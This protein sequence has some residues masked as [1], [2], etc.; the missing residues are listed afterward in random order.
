MLAQPQIT[1]SRNWTEVVPSERAPWY[2]GDADIKEA[3][4]EA[5]DYS[6][7][8]CC[9]SKVRQNQNSP[10]PPADTTIE[11]KSNRN[12]SICERLQIL[13]LSAT[14][15]QTTGTIFKRTK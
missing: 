7:K 3:S 11:K 8:H 6:Y 14:D 1:P 12:T 9:A 4:N 10:G 13:K 15:F 5:S 2:L